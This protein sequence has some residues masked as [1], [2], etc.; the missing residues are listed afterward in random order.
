MR[1]SISERMGWFDF[2]IYCV[3]DGCRYREGVDWYTDSLGALEAGRCPKCNKHLVVKR[4]KQDGVP[5]DGEA[6][7]CKKALAC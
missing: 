2:H 6:E 1:P 3:K 7:S 5:C 4:V